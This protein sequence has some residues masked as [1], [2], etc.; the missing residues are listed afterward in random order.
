MNPQERPKR[1][2]KRHPVLEFPALKKPCGRSLMLGL[3]PN[4]V[5]CGRVRRRKPF[6]YLFLYLCPYAE[7]SVSKTDAMQAGSHKHFT[8]STSRFTSSTPCFTS[9]TSHLTSTTSSFTS[10]VSFDTCC[11]TTFV[12]STPI[13]RAF[14]VTSVTDQLVAHTVF[15]LRGDF[16]NLSCHHLKFLLYQAIKPLQCIL[17]IGPPK[18][19]LGK[20]LCNNMSREA[21]TETPLIQVTHS[22]VVAPPPLSQWKGWR[23]TR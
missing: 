20:Y 15:N 6:V 4:I 21:R 13:G 9:T 8:S 11:M 3:A 2:P 23:V 22:L 16:Q 14:N 18:Q 5:I 10:F 17:D 7:D 1:L 19:F 12:L